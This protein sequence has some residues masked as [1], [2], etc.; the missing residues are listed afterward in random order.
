MMGQQDR[1]QIVVAD[2]LHDEGLKI[3]RDFG[4]VVEPADKSKEAL[5]EAVAEADAIVVRSGTTI[6]ADIIDA[7]PRL[8]V[9]ARAGVGVDNI[10]VEAA[11]RRGIVVV[12]SPAGNTIAAAEMTIA[13]M[14]AIAR[15]V[16][17]AAAAMKSGKC[18]RKKYIGRQV[19][20]KVLGVIGF[21][22]IGR[23]VAI[24]AMG[25]GM[26]VLAH[27]PFVSR[28]A[29]EQYGAR[30]AEFEEVLRQADF[31]SLHVDLREENRH[32]IG[33]EQLR[34]MK[35]DAVLINCARGALVDED[36]LVRALK[37]GWIA[38]AAL[39][40]L[41][42]EK[43]PNPELLS[44]P[45]AVVTPHLGASTIEAQAQVAVDAAEQVV[46]VLEGRA[47]RWAVNAPALPP[48]AEED[49]AP[50]LELACALGKIA[51]ALADRLYPR[52]SVMGPAELADDH[53]ELVTRFA[54]AEYLSAGAD[55]PVN[56][57]NVP[58]VAAE[59]GVVIAP[60]R[61]QGPEGYQRWLVM[62]L[63]DG[64][65][66]VELAGA[67]VGGPPRVVGI[68]GFAVDFVP[69]GVCLCIWHGAP[70]QPGFIG[71]VGTILGNRGISITGIEVGLE[72]VDGVGLMIVQVA[73]TLDQQVI[74]E[75]QGLEGVLRTVV[76]SFE[77]RERCP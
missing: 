24:R 15:N 18:D 63:S 22:R 42:D 65:G 21:G 44:L 17:Q 13:L 1:P 66:G 46:A 70:G 16:P 26:K 60:Q 6:T 40:V 4:E 25:L 73:Q 28:Q 37:E 62:R 54:A 14:L 32:M 43:N 5:L 47:P 53:L 52:C 11:T 31:V 29:I 10:D 50:Y 7:A 51:A 72:A 68:D 75:I 27:D 36:A 77:E 64:D 71:R 34:L 12:N 48:E 20:G 2:P 59:R 57:V 35:P 30:A 19:D 49:V 56:Y 39:D 3:L 61:G 41:E 9:I 74:S 67:L 58:M 33:E 38:G 45:N 23:A 55:Q 76:V 8:K 69:R